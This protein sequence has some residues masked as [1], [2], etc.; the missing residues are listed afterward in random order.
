MLGV[1]LLVGAIARWLLL[2]V[3][4]GDFHAFMDGW[5]TH[6]AQDGFSGLA[7]DFSNYNTPYL[8]L[9]WAATKLPLPELYAIKALS[10][11]FDG[12]LVYFSYRIVRLARPGS[13]WW[14]VGAASAVALL[15]TVVMNGAAWAQCDA[16][17]ASLLLGSLSFLMERRLAWAAGLFGLAFAFKLQAVF[18]LP[19]LGLVVLLNRLRWRGLLAVPATFFAALVPAALAGRGL[20]DQLRVYPEQ[21]GNASGAVASTRSGGAPEAFG[22]QL[23]LDGGPPSISGGGDGGGS[24]WTGHAFTYNAPT[25]YAWLPADAGEIWKATGIGVA[26]AVGV[27]F[28]VWLLLRRRRLAP[29][30]VVLVAAAVTFVVPWLLPEMHERYF[31]LAE[32][33]L[34]VAVAVVPRLVI[35]A[36]CLEAASVTTYVGYLR[37]VEILPLETSA[38]LAAVAAVSTAVLVVARLAQDGAPPPVDAVRRL[39]APVPAVP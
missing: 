26:V 6:L 16:I 37:G 18:F 29:S 22:R 13:R 33:L 35:P 30:D 7:D 5:Y 8:V 10:V 3:Q 17:Y 34:V 2:P 31:Y 14:P 1:A 19:V 38:A 27:T 12:L 36:L 23:G 24:V 9:L 21:V 15:P 4:S 11:V 32:V 39:P 20:A 25:P 28:A